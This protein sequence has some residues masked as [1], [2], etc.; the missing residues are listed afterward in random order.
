M[1]I[2]PAI[3]F[4]IVVALIVVAVFYLLYCFRC[5]AWPST[6]STVFWPFAISGGLSSTGL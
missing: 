3:V 4:V 2:V 5:F 6:T 1:E